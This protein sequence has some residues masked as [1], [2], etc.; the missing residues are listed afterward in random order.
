MSKKKKIHQ[1][2][3]TKLE[4]NGYKSISEKTILG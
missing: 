2:A 1:Q 3:N 4:E